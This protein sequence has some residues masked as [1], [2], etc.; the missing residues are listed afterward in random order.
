ML[1]LRATISRRVKVS[2]RSGV[3]DSPSAYSSFVV[4]ARMHWCWCP[5]TACYHVVSRVHPHLAG[6][7][8]P[9]SFLSCHRRCCCAVIG[10][11]FFVCAPFPGGVL[12]GGSRQP[13]V[14]CGVLQRLHPHPGIRVHFYGVL[15]RRVFAGDLWFQSGVL[16]VVVR[17]SSPSLL[18]TPLPV[19]SGAI[20]DGRRSGRA[21]CLCFSASAHGCCFLFPRRG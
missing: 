4:A 10:G 17:I 11:L 3:N 19:I 9:V 16:V 21:P 2:E 5:L 14:S 20:I 7:L 13:E 1:Y 12:R 15:Q 18:P 8:K 6:L